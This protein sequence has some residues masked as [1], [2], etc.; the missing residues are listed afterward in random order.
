MLAPLRTRKVA[1]TH[2]HTHTHT[3][4]MLESLLLGF[5]VPHYRLTCSGIAPLYEYSARQSNGGPGNRFK[6]PRT[7]RSTALG[8][9]SKHVDELRNKSGRTKM[10][11]KRQTEHTYGGHHIIYDMGS[12]RGHDRFPK[13]YEGSPVSQSEYPDIDILE[14]K[15]SSI[16]NLIHS[17]EMA[18]LPE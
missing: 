7:G 16:A 6:S 13:H 4:M 18:P 2:T 3:H 17:H 11:S 9:Y 8:E 5:I 15:I 10:N 12:L 14:H 1:N